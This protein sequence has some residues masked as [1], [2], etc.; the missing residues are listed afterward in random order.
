MPHQFYTSGSI[1]WDTI[2]SPHG[3]LWAT[4]GNLVEK[5]CIRPNGDRPLSARSLRDSSRMIARISSDLY[6]VKLAGRWRAD[7]QAVT[8][9]WPQDHPAVYTDYH[10]GICRFTSWITHSS[11]KAGL[12]WMISQDEQ[13]SRWILLSQFML[14]C[15]CKYQWS[16]LML[17]CLVRY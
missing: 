6:K 4:V 1:R 13:T 9:R 14:R 10:A 11:I 15:K 17:W 5:K 16:K 8:C 7:S 3:D 2:R 12:W